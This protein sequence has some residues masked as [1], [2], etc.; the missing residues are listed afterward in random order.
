MIRPPVPSSAGQAV[1]PAPVV[2]PIALAQTPGEAPVPAA[3]MPAPA[4]SP[5]WL[6]AV[7]QWLMPLNPIVALAWL[8]GVLILSSRLALAWAQLSRLRSVASA[9]APSWQR[10]LDNLA[11]RLAITR[12]VRLLESALVQV[13]TVLGHLRPLVLVPVAAL[14]ELAPEQ[15]EALL[16]HELAHIQAEASDKEPAR[17]TARCPAPCPSCGAGR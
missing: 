6:S 17:C 16:A 1:P 15:L 4:A 9:A 13:P 2:L 10:R 11:G 12:P 14:T 7:G 3:L 8:A 5:R